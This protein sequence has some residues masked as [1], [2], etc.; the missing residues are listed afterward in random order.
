MQD[1]LIEVIKIAPA[2][3]QTLLLAVILV[4]FQGPIR[5]LLPSLRSFSGFG[6]KADFVV[7]SIDQ[8]AASRPNQALTSATETNRAAARAHRAADLLRGEADSLD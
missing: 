1:V 7:K 6:I 3:F 5:E 2:L 8:A 4:L